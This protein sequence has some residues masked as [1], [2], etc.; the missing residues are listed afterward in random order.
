[1]IHIDDRQRNH[2]LKKVLNHQKLQPNVSTSQHTANFRL[3]YTAAIT[4][5][6]T[7]GHPTIRC[8][9]AIVISVLL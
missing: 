9:F 6:N 8:H 1:V 4:S 5:H 3:Y 2:V 7:T